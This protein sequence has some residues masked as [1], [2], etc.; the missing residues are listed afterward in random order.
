MINGIGKGGTGRID[1]PRTGASQGAAA[2]AVGGAQ[3]NGRSGSAG[4]VVSELVAMGPPVDSEKVAAIRQA[5]A[6]GRYGV[7]ADAI[8]ERMI[9]SDLPA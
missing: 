7:D 6:E 8:A 5:I 3:A 1:L 2:A 4:S 9:A